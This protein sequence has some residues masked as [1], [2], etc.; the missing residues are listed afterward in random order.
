MELN[1]FN[2]NIKGS[3]IYPAIYWEKFPLFRFANFF[4]KT[5]FVLFFLNFLF[6]V[7]GFKDFNFLPFFL[8]FWIFFAYIEFFFNDKLKKPRLK[9]TIDES[10]I[11]PEEKNLAN[12]LNFEAGRAVYR[13]LRF[14]ISQDV[15]IINSDI[16]FYFILKDN[17]KINFIFN[18]LLINVKEIRDA[19]KNYL[20]KIPSEKK[21]ERRKEFTPDFQETILLAMEIAKNKKKER[22]DEM[23]ILN[24]LAKKNIFFQKILIEKDLKE[25]DIDNLTYWVE[26]V[27]KTESQKKKFWEYENLMKIGT[28][29]KEWTAGY[30]ITLDK[31][32][33]DLTEMIKN[34]PPEI[35]GHEAEIK[36][37]EAILARMEINNV[38]LVGKP[39]TGRK[40]I[41]YNLAKKSFLGQSLPEIN[42]KRII[43][44]DIPTILNQSSNFS[45]VKKLLDTIFQEVVF[46]GNIILV[47]DNFHEYV[48]QMDKI[49]KFDI[50]EVLSS[51]LHLPQFQIIAITTYE[52]LHK[53]IEQNSSLLY[54]FDKVEVNEV[55]KKETLILLENLTFSLE[56]KY[57]KFISYPAIREII[58]LTD[59][60]M[61]SLDFPEKAMEV[62]EEVVI[63]VYKNFQEKIILPKHVHIII[64]EK[65]QIPIGEIEDKEKEIL[66]NLENL[67]HQKI[68]DQDEA[69]KEIAT[70][71]QRSRAQISIRKG[72]MGC[73]LFLGPTGVGKTE[74]SKAL[75]EIYF[76]GEKRM[77]RLDMSEFQSINDIPRLIGAPGQEGLL[78]TPVIENPFSLVLLD[79]FEKANLNLLNLFLQVL[80]EGHL[81]DGQGRK[82]DFRSTIIIATSNAGYQIILEALKENLEWGK[83]KEKLLD[84]IFK[85]G[86]FRPELINRFDGVVVFKPLDKENL[87]SIAELSLQKLKNNLYEKGIQFIIND[88][89]KEKIVEL[90]YD[91]KFGAREMRRVIQEKVENVLA[92]AILAGELK[93]GD[94]LEIDP[95]NF[96]LKVKSFTT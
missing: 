77:I 32:S 44:L 25:E 49:E 21:E 80:D 46:A 58:D 1:K 57:K 19:L 10:L 67:I 6:F 9:K 91:P 56:G 47:I 60:Y 8:F 55:S 33:I 95:T 71:L 82:V 53:N 89:L 61:P 86:I 40:S 27:E 84:F 30:T 22:V 75:A 88:D 43:Q 90:S 50:T 37:L 28:L 51:Y 83:V 15:S 92:R 14:A 29:A 93:R 34:T 5:F 96:T 7:F 85:Q 70:A 38:L 81:T 26:H 59:K 79:E 45:E 18:R 87:L 24:A 72:P 12:F 65:T 62:L 11:S 13:S 16:L 36:S 20:L 23:D 63:Y 64:R 4:K 54:L 39:G 68:I 94:I 2:F 76:G 42:H 52:G 66:L 31:Y 35:I 69:V 48:G 41:V 78:T 73:F 17:L 74:T 3:I